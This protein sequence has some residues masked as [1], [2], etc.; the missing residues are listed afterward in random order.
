M[1]PPPTPNN[2]RPIVDQLIEKLLERKRIGIERYGVALQMDNGRDA[3]ADAL[4]EALDLTV[5][6]M[7][8]I[9]ERDARKSTQTWI[10]LS[11]LSESVRQVMLAEE[12]QRLNGDF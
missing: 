9:A 3:L 7:Q 12:R 5:Y 1:Q 2:N 8:A 11:G 6:L 4:D 10:P